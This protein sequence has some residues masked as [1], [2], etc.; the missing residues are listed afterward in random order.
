MTTGSRCG[1]APPFSKYWILMRSGSTAA[2]AED[3]WGSIKTEEKRRE[4][5]LSPLSLFLKTGVKF[6]TDQVV[7]LYHMYTQCIYLIKLRWTQYSISIYSRV[8]FTP[9]NFFPFHDHSSLH[10]NSCANWIFSQ[11]LI[12]ARG[13]WSAWNKWIAIEWRRKRLQ[14]LY[15]LLWRAFDCFSC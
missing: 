4:S 1:L 11:F 2:V 7:N 5:L 9:M 14:W 6:I 10:Q 3:C 8:Q 15:Q 13:S 12:A